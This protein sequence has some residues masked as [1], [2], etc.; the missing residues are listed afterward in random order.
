MPVVG[1]FLHQPELI[2]NGDL[3]HVT[4]SPSLFGTTVLAVT[5]AGIYVK[6]QLKDSIK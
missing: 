2:D 1:P 3:I 4:K 5:P 6:I